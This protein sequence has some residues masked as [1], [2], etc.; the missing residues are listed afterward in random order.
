MEP[1]ER[2]QEDSMT[3]ERRVR[4]MRPDERPASLS[5]QQATQ[6]AKGRVAAWHTKQIDMGVIPPNQPS[7]TAGPEAWDAFRASP[8]EV[9][10]AADR[11]ASQK[12]SLE[13]SGDKSMA[14]RNARISRERGEERESR[15]R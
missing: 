14:A 13:A 8:D 3:R 9:A 5:S 4:Q 12:A 15:R 10:R 6:D 1:W 7:P 2:E 11:A